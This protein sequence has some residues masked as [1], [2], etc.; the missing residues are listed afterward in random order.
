MAKTT[1][2]LFSLTAS[3]S[4]GK[5][6]VYSIW[7]GVSYVRTLV[8]PFNPQS[9]A[10]NVA[11]VAIGSIGKASKAVRTKFHI[12]Y[13]KGSQFYID[14]VAAAPT[15]LAWNSYMLK[16]LIGVGQAAFSASHSA[17]DG[18]GGTPQGVYATA[19]A[20]AG[21]VDFSFSYGAITSVAKGEQLYML[22]SFAL[23]TLGYTLSAGTLASPDAG[24]LSDFVE[25]LQ[26]DVV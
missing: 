4:M 14:A 16:V 3:G 23:S 17:Y 2:P 1:G 8:T 5:T 22:V 10:Q 9:D 21:I 13:V 24:G 19:A 7:N 18:L 20:A 26:D 12:A 11:R 6:I 15:G 25:Y